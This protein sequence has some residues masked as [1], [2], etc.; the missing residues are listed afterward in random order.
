MKNSMYIISVLLVVIWAIIYF[1]F[2]LYET[3]SYRIVHLILLI[4]V[5][6]LL[7]EII[8]KYLKGNK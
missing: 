6:L 3:N 5:I 8:R 1:G 4:A 2:N 7:Y